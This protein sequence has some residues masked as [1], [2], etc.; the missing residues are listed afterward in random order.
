M[1]RKGQE[2]AFSAGYLTTRRQSEAASQQ[3]DDVPGHSLVNH[4]PAQ[5]R[6]GGF[7]LLTCGK[8]AV[9]FDRLALQ[10]A[11]LKFNM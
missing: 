6:F 10:G 11:G 4:L 5:Q 2:K 8:G 3:Q 1:R 7:H 9:K